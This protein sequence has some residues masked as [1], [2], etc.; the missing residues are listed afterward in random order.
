MGTVM[1]T[2]HIPSKAI[3]ATVAAMW[4]AGR[5]LAPFGLAALVTGLGL[6]VFFGVV[7]TLP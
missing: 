7:A 3:A 1:L 4:N 6:F 5:M 2:S